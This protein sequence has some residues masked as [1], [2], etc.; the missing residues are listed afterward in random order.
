MRGPSF[1][2]PAQGGVVVVVEGSSITTSYNPQ[3]GPCVCRQ[4]VG[5]TLRAP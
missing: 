4:G 1:E 5:V 3:W 2:V